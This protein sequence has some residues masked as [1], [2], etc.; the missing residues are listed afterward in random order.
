MNH[1]ESI[2]AM[3][4]GFHDVRNLGVRKGL[5]VVRSLTRGYVRIQCANGS[6]LKSPHHIYWSPKHAW[7]F[8][9]KLPDRD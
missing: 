1:R 7:H 8:L 6:L 5:T 3:A 9:R 4:V 2:A